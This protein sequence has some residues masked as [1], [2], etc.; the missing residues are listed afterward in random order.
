M[1]YY[2]IIISNCILQIAAS[3]PTR[4]LFLQLLLR[5]YRILHPCECRFRAQ[6]KVLK[7]CQDLGV[8]AQFGGKYFAHDVGGTQM[9]VCAPQAKCE[10]KMAGQKRKHFCLQMKVK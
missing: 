5:D 8:G 9:D 6:E 2:S 3:A 1:H 4:C 7:I 10:A